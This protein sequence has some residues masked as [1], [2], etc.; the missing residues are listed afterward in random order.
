V[1]IPIFEQYCSVNLNPRPD[2]SGLSGTDTVHELQHT[3]QHNTHT[4]TQ[5]T[6]TQ[7]T[8]THLVRTVIQEIKDGLVVDLE[9]G[10][11]ESVA[12]ILLAGVH[13]REQ[14]R[15]SAGGDA[16]IVAVTLHGKCL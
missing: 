5:F 15:D 7:H 11:C 4:A 1:S 13:D 9:H 6:P 10:E 14:L 12:D 8:R 3:H 16:L 2:P